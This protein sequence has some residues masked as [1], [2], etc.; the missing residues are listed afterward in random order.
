MK[1]IKRQHAAIAG[2]IGLNDAC[3]I[4]SRK[5]AKPQRGLFS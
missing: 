3:F 2:I 1:I 4:N 5:D